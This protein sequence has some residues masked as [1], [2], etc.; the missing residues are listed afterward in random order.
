MA[1]STT[2]LYLAPAFA[3]LIGF[4]LLA[5]VPLVGEMLGGLVVIA[6]VVLVSLGDRSRPSP[7]VIDPGRGGGDCGP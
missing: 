7:K 4:I 1:P 6:A 5:E 3:V 2:P